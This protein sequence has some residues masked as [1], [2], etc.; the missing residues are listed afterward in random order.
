M[1]NTDGNVQPQDYRHAA[2]THSHWL[3]KHEV[4]GFPGCPVVRTPRIHSRGHGF[5]PWSGNKDPTCPVLWPKKKKYEVYGQE[6]GVM[7]RL[8]EP[9]RCGG[10]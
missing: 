7:R 2:K 9:G 1:V 5:D 3:K 4:G 8:L 10:P 6:K